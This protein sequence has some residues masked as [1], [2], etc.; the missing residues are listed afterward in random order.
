LR[1]ADLEQAQVYIFAQ[2]GAVQYPWFYGRVA[3]MPREVAG[4]TTLK[5]TGNDWECLRQ[6]V[7]YENF[8]VVYN[9][10]RHS[11]Q[12]AAWSNSDFL[13]T[14]AKISLLGSHYCAHHGITKFD[15][16]GR[17]VESIKKTGGTD[18]HLLQIDL[19]NGIKCGTYVI[20][21][22]DATNYTVTF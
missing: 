20:A 16:G 12:Q 18:I 15:G 6:P 4:V 7:V 13:A 8:G 1:R 5:I 10:S 2:I 11:S 21:F 3:G 22:K 14:A 9:G 17:A 19:K